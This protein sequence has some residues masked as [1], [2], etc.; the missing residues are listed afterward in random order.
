MARKITLFELNVDGITFPSFG[1]V[2]ASEDS[3]ASGASTE[4]S[5]DYEKGY[6]SESSGRAGRIVAVVG[7]VVLAAAVR[8]RLARRVRNRLSERDASD[9]RE[10]TIDDPADEPDAP[11]VD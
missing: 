6:G 2:P 5:D 9:E 10:I 11:T 1:S 3:D 4:A 7:A 8:R